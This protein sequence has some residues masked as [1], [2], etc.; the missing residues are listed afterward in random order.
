MALDDQRRIVLQK[1]IAAAVAAATPISFVRAATRKSTGKIPT[2]TVQSLA[3]GR[4][5]EIVSNG[6]ALFGRVIDSSGRAIATVPA[7]KLKLKSGKTL[8]FDK[9]GRLTQGELSEQ[10]F[11]LFC[12][13]PPASCPPK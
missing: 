4:K 6:D 2:K 3:D 1:I 11:L 12:D 9:T 8:T 10:S 13:D 7:G 5:I